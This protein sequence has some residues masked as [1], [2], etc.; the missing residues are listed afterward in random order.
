M[1]NKVSQ[2]SNK[3]VFESTIYDFFIV[4]LYLKKIK[5]YDSKNNNEFN[6]LLIVNGLFQPI[7]LIYNIHEKYLIKI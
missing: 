1:T 2:Y 6:K 7:Q 3:L 5:L 4:R